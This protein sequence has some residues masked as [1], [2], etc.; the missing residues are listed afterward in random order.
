MSS[1]KWEWF[2][3]GNASDVNATE[4]ATDDGFLTGECFANAVVALPSAVF[5]VAAILILILASCWRRQ[6]D[7]PGKYL[8]RYPGHELRWI[9]SLVL[10]VLTLAALSEGAMSE[11][12]YRTWGNTSHPHLYL[13]GVALLV[14]ALVSSAYYHSLEIW[15]MKRLSWFLL[16]FWAT[17]IST[18]SYRLYHYV[19]VGTDSFQI[20]RFDITIGLLI[21]YIVLLLNEVYFLS[22]ST[23]CFCYHGNGKANL[24]DLGQSDLKFFAEYS[25]LPSEVSYWWQNWLFKL[26]SKK[27][28]DVEDLGRVP[29]IHAAA[30]NHK[31]FKRMLAREK[32]KC[33][34]LG[35]EFSVFKTMWLTYRS[36]YILASILKIVSDMIG[37]VSRF[38]IVAI[39]NYVENTYSKPED[40]V[41][42]TTSPHAMTVTEFFSN[43]YV[44]VATVFVFTL[45]RTIFGQYA[46]YISSLEGL[47]ARSALQ[48]V[49]YEK[50]LRLSTYAMSSGMMTMGQ[51]TNH[52]SVDC[53][54][55]LLYGMYA[56]EIVCVPLR[57]V[58]NVIL[59]IAVLGYPALIAAGLFLLVIPVQFVIGTKVSGYLK[60]ILTFADERLKLSNEMLQGIKLLK[61]Y[62]WEK[63][64]YDSIRRI[65]ET[66]LGY[67]VKEYIVMAINFSMVFAVPV[68]LTLVAFG[69]FTSITGNIL[70]PG[71]T[72]T[73]L[74]LFNLLT[75]PLFFLPFIV[76][77][78]ICVLVSSRRLSTYLMAP[79]IEELGTGRK[80]SKPTR[81]ETSD[82]EKSPLRFT[83]DS[84]TYGA[85]DITYNSTS[86]TT[87]K[88]PDDVAIRMNCGN[89][90]WDPTSSEPILCDINVDVPRGK[91][92]TIVGA[93]GS[94]KSS[95]LQAMMGEMTT[96]S[97]TVSFNERHSTIAYAGQ[98]AWLV[99]ASLKENILFGQPW[100]EHRYREVID[101]CALKPDI[102]ML[103]AGDLTEIGEKGINLS[104]GQ[105]QRVSVGRALYS[106]KDIIIMDDPLSALDVHVGG[107]LFTHGI[108][109]LLRRQNQTVVLVTHQ[110]QYLPE[111]D[112]IIVMKDGRIT[113]HG[114]PDEVALL[115]PDLCLDWTRAVQVVSETETESGAESDGVL[116]ER[117]ALRKQ[118]ARAAIASAS[119]LS[120]DR[121]EGNDKG[122]LIEEEDREKGAVSIQVY[123]YYAKF[124]GYG[125]LL[126]AFVA[127]I[128]KSATQIGSN[129][130][131]SQWT[132]YVLNDTGTAVDRT[133]FWEG[134]YAALSLTTIVFTCV[135]VG[136]A[137]IGAFSAATKMHYAIL[138]NIIHLPMRFFD[139]TPVGRILNR[140]SSDFKLIDQLLVHAVRN[141]TFILANIFSSVVVLVIVAWY[142][143]FFAIPITGIFVFLLVY[144][145][146][147]SREL[148]RCESVSRS[149]V[150]AHFSESLGGLP[151]IR[152][153]K[154]QGRYFD[155]IIE[156]IDEN[157]TV[158]MHLQTAQR[159]IAFRL[160][161]LG[162]VVVLIGS[163]C[164]LLGAA[165]FGVESSFV[166]LA[167][168]Y[169]FDI[170]TFINAAVQQCAELELHMNAVERVQ[171]YIEV[172]PENYE[173]LEPPP[174]WPSKG[175]IDIDG[176]NVRYAS[177]L[178]PVLHDVTLTVSPL[179][180]LGICG[181]TGSGKSSLTLA[182]FRMIDT[183]RGS[184]VIDGIDIAS[185]PLRTL[186]QR[187]SIIPQDA[188][189]FT[190]SIRSNLDPTGAKTDSE[191]WYALE[192]AQLKDVVA[193]IPTGLD[194]TVTEGGENFSVG[195]RQLFC[196]ARAFLRNSK[197][198]VMDEAT[199]SI[200]HETDKILQDVVADVFEN[201]TVLT[202][203]HR[204]S[205]ILNS[206]AIL[207]LS[208]GRVAEHDTPG[209]LLKQEESIFAS[210]VKAGK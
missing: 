75:D 76:N 206:D 25:S 132:Y 201:N 50:S 46:L 11:S 204:V 44:L 56:T 164:A 169:A 156:R 91:L 43:A 150:F 175:E 148:Q 121:N 16:L 39:V 33:S 17:S 24:L 97:G 137:S 93:V 144:Y 149:P 158:V 139:T 117:K 72:F 26:G 159:W 74:S 151:T 103:P 145:M 64:F 146:K 13:S 110:L 98:K 167:I 66:E 147:T 20:L 53:M 180:K 189:L 84:T 6:R 115:D 27:I 174:D 104:G 52:M 85:T 154:E 119:T 88:M 18:M 141:V 61:L 194:Y 38:A 160:D 113:S 92:T 178:D 36:T 67:L 177:E 96:L 83:E 77:R 153:Y 128:G 22:V 100:D 209:N 69:S 101:A 166:G 183:F 5:S 193:S 122:R 51:I 179:E 87:E 41:K 203:A 21:V 89:F 1:G 4:N 124:M 172:P 32:E 86:F 173:G 70:S 90:T 112:K 197:I 9:V 48:A 108:T 23:I 7:R 138:S 125:W 207:T 79:E 176:I 195:Q 107:H 188:V 73:A 205:T 8:V 157:N 191:L 40:K 161:L 99:N 133:G 29:E 170:S 95:L 130:W 81:E 10:F 14:S 134:G 186:R 3:G 185:V 192:I 168:A 30:Y 58:V 19:E 78:F 190:G 59:L 65:R 131:L 142:F 184:I 210:L 140:L 208:N 15:R 54:N 37:L 28:L 152:A 199:A 102:D 116:R 109:K 62:G 31:R 181:R 2:C 49:V 82:S 80:P 155:T 105:K 165:Y 162:N 45:I 202:I 187:L 182:L 127:L 118:I 120:R 71:V 63:L 57:M 198:V 123:F 55:V 47:H 111:A 126:L 60:S 106:Q 68:L 136:L 42:E 163:L 129:I 196:L 171:Y 114:T 135:A 143:I 34:A 35:K 94:G 12:L 200:D